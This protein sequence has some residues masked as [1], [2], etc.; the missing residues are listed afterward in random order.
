MGFSGLNRFF[1]RRCLRVGS[2]KV[3]VKVHTSKARS[4]KKLSLS[5]RRIIT[6]NA[7]TVRIFEQDCGKVVFCKV[8]L[9]YRRSYQLLYS[10][11]PT[12]DHSIKSEIP[13]AS[14]P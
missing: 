10:F 3:V 13:Y 6:E 8:E 2:V 9:S 7:E 4:A 11:F 5:L 1:E 12:H 14:D